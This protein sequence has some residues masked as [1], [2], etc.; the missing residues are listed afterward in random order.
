MTAVKTYLLTFVT[1]SIACSVFGQEQQDTLR[2]SVSDAQLYAL[3]YNRSV[4]AS[5]ID[6][7]VAKKVILETT[8]IGLPQFSIKADYQHIFEVPEISF[9]VAGFSQDSL[10]LQRG[11]YEN[12]NQSKS[13]GDLYYYEYTTPGIPLGTKNNTTFNFTLSQLIFSG[14]Y[15]VGLQAARIFKE[16]SEKASIKSELT[17]KESVATSYY[18]VLVLDEN[19]RVL[20]ESLI[21][22][23]RTFNDIEAM[24]KQGFVEDTDVDQMKLNQSNLQ[25]MVSSLQS[26]KEVALKLLKF[27]LGIDFSRQIVLTENLEGIVMK[28]NFQYL[29]KDEFNVESNI[30]FKMMETQVDLMSASVR[31]EKSKYLP[32]ISGFYQHQEMTNAPA[33]NF[34]PKDLIG[35]SMNLPIVTSGQRIAKV[36]QA[37][38]MLEKTVLSKQDAEQGLIM[39]FETAKNEYQTAFLN[40][41]NYKESMVLSEKIYNKN[42][43]K[44]KA[45]VGT[46]LELTQSQNQYLTSESNYYNSL[47]SLLK[48]KAK[49]DRIVANN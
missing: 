16:V 14:E 4:Q 18:L 24:N 19:L 3:E 47:I 7:E 30:D 36:S 42:I 6:V 32:T 37:K 38:L 17:T 35:L 33:F 45:G 40:Y 5:K 31:R 11:P 12:F 39:E 49:I 1:L 28:G 22:L 2:L 29:L 10:I 13:L 46:S 26:Q 34:M 9:P 25:N 20:D 8:A 23:N 41:T 44:Y 21:L 48:A 27:Q 43:I 15:I